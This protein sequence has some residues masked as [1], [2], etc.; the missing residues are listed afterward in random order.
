MELKW[1]SKALSDLARLFEFLALANR[2]AAAN[3]VKA[4]V[5]APK[6]LLDNP[7]LGERLDEFLPQE[8][9][10]ILVGRYGYEIRYQ[11]KPAT[12]YVLR[13]RHTREER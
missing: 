12:I 8:V 7:R 3:S 2:T 9:R 6:A 5:A 1:T 10:R 4:L 11:V 13:I